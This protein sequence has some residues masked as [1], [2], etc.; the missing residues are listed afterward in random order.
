MAH[1]DSSNEVRRADSGVLSAIFD[2]VEETPAKEQRPES[3]L[4]RARALE[5]MDVARQLDNML[6]ITSRRFWVA[7][8][9]VGIAIIAALVY[10]A[11]VV[12]I[13]SVSAVGRAVADTGIAQAASPV[14]GVL[15]RTEV[16]QGST[17]SAGEVVASGTRADGSSLQVLA[18]VG[19]IVWQ[20]LATTGQV[21]QA[22]E[23]VATVLPQGSDISVLL[24]LTESQAQSVRPGLKVELVGGFGSATGEVISVSSAPVPA[25]IAAIQVAQPL[26][27][28][29]PIIMV[30]IRA[31]SPLP[32]GASVQATIV[33]AEET[34]LN[35]LTGL[36]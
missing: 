34:L 14:G 36:Q 25:G 27:P 31:D 29:T 32:A 24:P 1:R 22:G 5:Q 9:G 16:A 13:T 30:G 28:Q 6:P 8:I 21:V 26:E 7:L 12:Q 2:A 18:P 33:I 19:G 35:Q 20:L 15:T 4:F 11:G 3:A 23:I 17:I 10:A